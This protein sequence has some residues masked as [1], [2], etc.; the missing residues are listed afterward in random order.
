MK[1]SQEF[2]IFAKPAGAVCNLD[3]SYCYYLPKKELYAS[4]L[5]QEHILDE[6]IRQYI[7]ASPGEIIRFSWHGGEPTIAGLEF[8]RLAV[9][10]QNKYKP[11]DK[12]IRNGMQTNGILLDDDW[13]RFFAAENFAIG[14]S[15]DGP[16]EMHDRYRL[17]TG[18][19][20]SF[21]QT[22]RGYDLLRRHGI[23]PDIL[24]VLN[25]YNAQFPLE[26]Y[27]FFR[28]IGSDYITFLPLVERV[29]NDTVS[30][31]SVS[32]AAF[33]QFMRAVFDEWSANDIGV[34]K[35]N[36][37]EEAART[38]FGTEHEVCIFRETCGDIPVVEH[39]GD[40]YC[41][42][43]YVNSDHLVGN[44]TDRSLASMLESDLQIDFGLAKKNR[45]PSKCRECDVLAMCNGE[46]PKNRF[47]TT[48]DGE[49]GLNYLCEGYLTIFRHMIPF[50]K[51]LSRVSSQKT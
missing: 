15:L 9:E 10:L 27:R 24:C 29:S 4:N 36:L 49:P 44:I 40:F 39:N 2:Q 14:L 22:M 45:L 21:L 25:D 1:A 13:C 3:C 43:H 33:G 20:G 26:V 41:C 19:R 5:M 16:E 50:V 7:S 47:I 18:G 48:D 42:D 32:A 31:R 28:D 17:T 6:Y 8:Y 51:E 12:T 23:N 30:N 37:F 11:T 46:C 38:A 34:I 35:I